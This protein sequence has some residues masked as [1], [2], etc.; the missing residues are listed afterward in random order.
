MESEETQVSQYRETTDE[1]VWEVEA[2][3]P[4]NETDEVTDAT[5][6]AEVEEAEAEAEAEIGAEEEEEVSERAADTTAVEEVAGKSI[7]D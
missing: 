3:I 1:G 6:E 4:E 2:A 5:P 7:D